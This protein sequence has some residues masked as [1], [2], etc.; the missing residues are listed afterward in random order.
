MFLLYITIS[1]L[2]LYCL[3]LFKFAFV[4]FCYLND[5]C[6]RFGL[7]IILLVGV[8]IRFALINLFLCFT[9]YL[10]FRCFVVGFSCFDI[11]YRL[12]LVYGFWLVCLLFLVVLLV[13]LCLFWSLW[14]VWFALVCCVYFVCCCLRCDYLWF[15]LYVLILYYWFVS[16]NDV[17]FSLLGLCLVC[18]VVCA[19]FGFDLIYL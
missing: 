16:A 13:L 1:E 11:V 2:V 5:D 6:F 19:C 9:C 15:W 12:C 14:M 10:L 8:F 17:V 18:W 7:L 3:C 4:L